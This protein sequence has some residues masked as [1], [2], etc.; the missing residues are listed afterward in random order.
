MKKAKDNF[1]IGLVHIGRRE[2]SGLQILEKL[3]QH[4]F[5]VREWDVLAGNEKLNGINEVSIIIVNIGAVNFEY[6]DLLSGLFDY[7]IK[8]IINEAALTNQLS[9]IKR[10]SWE[11]HLL[12]KIDPTYSILP[13]N[14]KKNTHV[15]KLVDLKELGIEEVWILA[16]SIGGPDA[17]QKFLFEFKGDEKILFIIIQHIDKEFLPMLAQQFGQNSHFDVKVPISGM[18]IISAKCIIHPTDEYLH[19]DQKG[20]LELQAINDVF[21]FSPCIDECC[22]KLVNNVKNLNMAI[23]SG[24]STDGIEAAKMIRHNGNKVI[25]QSES[26]CVLSTII[27]GIKNEIE[28]DFDGTPAKMAEYIINRNRSNPEEETRNVK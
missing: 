15:N 21:A 13:D 14:S 3:K 9:G 20:I 23:F 4:D 7:D 25:T 28:I 26:S 8:I 27:D 22:K 17:I 10:Q 16:A 1:Y 19:F 18:K 2:K 5:L 6:D 11:R 12:N 24:M